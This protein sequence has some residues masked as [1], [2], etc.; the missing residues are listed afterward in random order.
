MPLCPVFPALAWPLYPLSYSWHSIPMADPTEQPIFDPFARRAPAWGLEAAPPHNAE[1]AGLEELPA[2][3]LEAGRNGDTAPAGPERP[4]VEPALSSPEAFASGGLFGEEAA[5]QAAPPPAMPVPDDLA[6]VA[7]WLD[8]GAP[9]EVPTRDP[10]PDAPAASAALSAGPPARQPDDLAGIAGWLEPDTAVA[11]CRTAA[12]S[13]EAGARSDGRD[14]APAPSP[15]PPPAAS[16]GSAG[17]GL[18]G[19]AGWLDEVQPDTSGGARFEASASDPDDWTGTEV[20]IQNLAPAA[21]GAPAP[22]APSPGRETQLAPAADP[23]D[24]A[25]TEVTIQSLEPDPSAA[26]VSGTPTPDLAAHSRQEAEAE[27]WTGTEVTIQSFASA[28]PLPPGTAGAMPSAPG[29]AGVADED[30]AGTEATIM[31]GANTGAGPAEALTAA[32][33]HERGRA[34]ETTPARDFRPPATHSDRTAE[35]TGERRDPTAVADPNRPA[36]AANDATRPPSATLPL[37]TPTRGV[38]AAW[39][40]SGRRGPATGETWGD[41]EIGGVLGEGGM[42]LVYRARQLSLNR[43]CAVKVLA[44]H[45]AS[46]AKVRER[47]LREAETTSLL[48]SPHVVNV[49]GAGQAGD[50]QFF[51]MEFVDGS[52]LAVQINARRKLEQPITIPEAIEIVIQA[53]QGLAE[54]DRHN[55]VHRDIKPA[56]I[57]VTRDNLVKIADFGIVKVRGESALTMTGQ[58][59]GTPSYISPEQGRGDEVD[60]RSDLYSLGVVFYQL[61]TGRRPFEGAT[62][63]ALIYQ[64]NYAEPERPQRLNPEVSEAIEAVVIKLLAKKPENRYQH[65]ADLIDD[66]QGIQDGSRLELLLQRRLSTGADEA[67]KENLSWLQR[68][69]TT[70]LILA[71]LILAV[72]GGVGYVWVRQENRQLLTAEEINT[73]RQALKERFDAEAELPPSTQRDIRDFDALIAAHP[74]LVRPDDTALI[75]DWRDRLAEVERLRQVLTRTLGPVDAQ[76]MESIA[77][78]AAIAARVALSRLS[79]EVGTSSVDVVAWHARLEE[80]AGRIQGYRERLEVL[81]TLSETQ[82]N[83]QRHLTL[84]RLF[85]EY[86]PLVAPDDADAER[87]AAALDAFDADLQQTRAAL[88][89]LDDDTRPLRHEELF[90]LT[91]ALAAYRRLDPDRVDDITR[92]HDALERFA[93]AVRAH[94]AGVSG[95]LPADPS[96]TLSTARI[97]ELATSLAWLERHHALDAAEL[98]TYHERLQRA[99]AA[100]AA[101]DRRRAELEQALAGLDRR[102]PI[103]PDAGALLDELAR[104]V[105]DDDPVVVSWRDKRQQVAQLRT[106]LAPLLA[107]PDTGAPPRPLPV[108]PDPAYVSDLAALHALVGAEGRGVRAY[109]AAIE[110]LGG[111]PRPVWAEDHGVDAH[112]PW[113][114]LSLPGT[115]RD[116][117]LL[118]RMRHVP[119]GVFLLGRA[120]DD[121]AADADEVPTHVR[122]SNGYWMLESEVTQAAYERVLGDNPSR[123][124]DPARPVERVAW[125]DTQRFLQALRAAVTGLA[126]RLPSEA[127][128]ERA[129]KAGTMA[130]YSGPRGA[131]PLA[132]L[133]RIAWFADNAAGRTHPAAVLQ[134][135]ALGLHDLHGNVWEWCADRYGP[136]PTQQVVDPLGRHGSARVVRGG[137]WGD[138]APLLRASNRLAVRTSMRSPYL[139]FRFVVDADWPTPPDGS[140]LLESFDPSIQR[141][142]LEAR[143]QKHFGFLL[144]VEWPSVI[145][146]IERTLAGALPGAHLLSPSAPAGVPVDHP[147]AAAPREDPP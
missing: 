133:E 90:V 116:A 64:H 113:A 3:D 137:S 117:D 78:D 42:G 91:E 5:E 26:A 139:G 100:K 9:T 4:L 92:W 80:H 130:P 53:A 114:T 72:G 14:N 43:K 73:R 68:H 62:P 81:D 89:R 35:V 141:I 122:L 37:K 140:T 24:W 84:D 11:D 57:F 61:L 79:E 63:N 96:Q 29:P 12:G 95:G 48:V 85:R 87:W 76:A 88:V 23:D 18:E 41:Y 34:D 128:W 51:V 49:F 77:Y 104:L 74:A 110:Q 30:W 93:T 123:F 66:L 107:V 82:R 134:P 145:A 17:D 106:R 126:P 118:L 103:P 97:A 131:Q 115:A 138:P 143:A 10:T 119:A 105:G 31:P 40:M 21:P 36:T 112:G 65:A 22:Q 6:Q 15:P 32:Q 54:A 120:P 111:P 146:W 144:E 50:N 38:D 101:F 28:T 147:P 102:A 52:D 124:A 83:R 59:M 2:P 121:S 108:R 16:T 132:Q 135:N 13:L 127:E 70:T 45:L 58:A 75:T 60:H 44:P 33:A 55:L 142:R 39:Q 125:D 20:T 7:A 47:F 98:A 46:D 86:V 8:L 27:D 136:Y 56:N 71:V 19:I 69:L 99:R 67:R 94:R 1:R 109:A 129:A 25:G